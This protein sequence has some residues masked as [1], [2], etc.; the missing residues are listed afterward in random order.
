MI[1]KPRTIV[2][3]SLLIQAPTGGYDVD[4]VINAGSNRWSLKLGLGA[5]WP[6]S[7]GW[8]F[9]ADI[10][11]WFF[12]DNDEFVGTT[13]EQ[14]PIGSVEFHLVRTI[15][16]SLWASLDL[17]Y[18]VGG[19]TTVGED[20]RADPQRNSRLGATVLIPFKGRH[21]IR[22]SFSTGIITDSGG[23]YDTFTLSYVYAWL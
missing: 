3:A 13:R 9:E 6:V 20:V 2:G 4:K 16:P 10:G 21:A 17:N 19:Q 8:L 18:Y 14:E 11:A 23:D 5:I 1:A 15:N 12:G 22:T 7:P